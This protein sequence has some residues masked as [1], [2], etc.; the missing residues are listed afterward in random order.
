MTHT[1]LCEEMNILPLSLVAKLQKAGI[2]VA[3]VSLAGGEGQ[4]FGVRSAN[5]TFAPLS[6]F[7]RMPPRAEVPHGSNGRDVERD[8]PELA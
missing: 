2:C 7:G 6:G 3:N 4:S 5:P 1:A 8:G